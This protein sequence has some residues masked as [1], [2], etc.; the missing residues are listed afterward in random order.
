MFDLA[1]VLF[2]FVLDKIAFASYR[3][4]QIIHSF[5]CFAGIRFSFDNLSPRDRQFHT[6]NNFFGMFDLDCPSPTKPSVQT[7]CF[8]VLIQTF[9]IFVH[10]CRPF[11][12]ANGVDEQMIT[13]TTFPQT[14]G[15]NS[16]V[17]HI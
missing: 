5:D 9:S 2:A 12:C 6:M 13:K 7:V 11:Y 8:F 14:F 15:D 10:I 4:C 16:D 17:D 1:F 3:P